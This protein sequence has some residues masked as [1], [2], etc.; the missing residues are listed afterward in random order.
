MADLVKVYRKHQ[1]G[2]AVLDRRIS[3]TDQLIDQIIYAL[4]GLIQDEIAI[5]EGN[6]VPMD[7]GNI[8]N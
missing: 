2:I 3:D 7:V 5:V 1:P 8:A 4:Y 6:A